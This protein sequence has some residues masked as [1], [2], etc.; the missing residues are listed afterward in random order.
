MGLSPR[1]FFS[2]LALV[3]SISLLAFLR[4]RQT[5]AGKLRR[6]SDSAEGASHASPPR[7]GDPGSLLPTPQHDDA[8]ILPQTHSTLERNDLSSQAV[9]RILHHFQNAEKWPL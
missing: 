6:S 3:T 2:T 4:L 5:F 9:G 7:G 8:C 1:A